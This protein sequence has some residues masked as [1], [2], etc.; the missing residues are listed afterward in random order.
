M[1]IFETINNLAILEVLDAY[2]IWYTKNGTWYVIK[3]SDGRKDESFSISVKDNIV[4]DFGKTWIKWWPFDFIGRYVLKQDTQTNIGKV[5]TIKSFI[6]KR[7][8]DDPDN[9]KPEFVK[10]L[11][12]IELFEQ[13]DDFKLWGYKKEISAFLMTRWF[14]HDWIWKKQ[15][16][17][18]ETFKD[19]WFY[20]NY[21][22]TEF[23]DNPEEKPKTVKV[24]LFPCYLPD[25]EGNKKLVWLKIRRIDGKTIRWQKSIAVKSP[26]KTW[27]LYN[28]LEQQEAIIV[29]GETDWLILTLLGYKNVVANLWGVQ[30]H[31]SNLKKLL[32]E[33]NK[34]I[35]LYDNDDAG[36]ISKVNLQ[37]IFNREVFD[38]EYPLRKDTKGK[39]LTDVNDYYRVGYDSKKKWD[40]LLKTTKIIWSNEIKKWKT[41]FILLRNSIEFY[42]IRAKRIQSKDAVAGIQLLTTKELFQMAK[43]WTL[44][45]YWDLCYWE[46]GKKDY[47]NILDESII[48]KHGWDAEPKLH[49]H[50]KYLIDNISGHKQKNA[51]W[52]HKSILYKLTHINDVWIPALVLY[53]SWWSWKGTFINLLSKIFGDDNTQ[54]WLGQNSLESW[55]DT[56]QWNKLIC[57]FK[58][59]SSGNKFQDKKVLDRMKSILMEPKITINPKYGKTR[60]VDNIARFHLS[61]NH[62]IPIQLDSKHSGNRRF[63]IIKTGNSL[64]S[65]KA[66]EMNQ[67]IFNDKQ[68]I[69]EYVAWLYETYPDIPN[70]KTLEALD[71][72]EKRNLEDACEWSSNLFFERFENKYDTV[73]RITNVEKN[74]LLNDYCFEVW[75]DIN[76]IKFKQSNFDLWLSHKYEKK[77]V[78]VRGKTARWYFINKTKFQKEKMPIDATGEFNQWLPIKIADK[79]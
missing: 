1:G 59:V 25:D 62:P 44:H 33:T 27:L 20:E 72:D 47:F 13:F 35:C 5:N 6:E 4:N 69:Q 17:I 55:Y 51:E 29:E 68:V 26:C 71:N 52:L 79:I 21:Y 2:G 54:I 42:D 22:C 16:L 45:T 58:E 34:I 77:I 23:K 75:E 60:E 66:Y 39:I 63:T 76:D 36:L 37:K 7:L 24:L 73:W 28:K 43:E 53:G 65:K 46:W 56:Y 8:I 12:D 19:F 67:I 10:S 18:W 3:H 11:K 41:D 74:L 78:R 48:V 15:L 70:S 57:E 32:A 9:N 64:D 40:V 50:I 30:S 14:S 38:I 49:T 31:G 61:S